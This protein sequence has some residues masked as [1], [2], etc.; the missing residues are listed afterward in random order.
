[1]EMQRLRESLIEKDQVILK[2]RK[3]NEELIK[4]QDAGTEHINKKP[5]LIP[6]LESEKAEVLQMKMDK[7]NMQTKL[8]MFQG[9]SKEEFSEMDKERQEIN[10][11]LKGRKKGALIARETERNVH[12][13]K[14]K[15]KKKVFTKPESSRNNWRIITVEKA[16]VDQNE[17]VKR[18]LLRFDKQNLGNHRKRKKVTFG[19]RKIY[20]F[21]SPVS[22]SKRPGIPAK[23]PY[24]V[25]SYTTLGE[26]CGCCQQ[27]KRLKG[28][29]T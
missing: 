4:G 12:F 22:T 8:E 28:D 24:V 18:R 25:Q 3:E 19:V 11:Q 27:L 26:P 21:G 23:E 16:F 9:K 5:V 13:E 2:L 6:E 29:S 15:G 7:E 20:T 10:T 1:M 14:L 17:R